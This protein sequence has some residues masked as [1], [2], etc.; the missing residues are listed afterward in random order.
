MKVHHVMGAALVVLLPLTTHAYTECPPIKLT[1]VWSD[2]NGNFFIGTVSN[3]NGTIDAVTNPP[4]AKPAI[5][6]AI[7]AY[8]A[9]R[10]V[11]IRYARDNVDCA[12]PAWSELIASIGMA[13]D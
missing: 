10:K 5:A 6:V 13:G 1:K 8:T 4:L 7:A 3:L 2:V 12:A 11:M 9:N